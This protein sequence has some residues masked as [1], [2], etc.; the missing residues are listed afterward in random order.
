MFKL[1]RVTLIIVQ[2]VKLQGHIWKYNEKY[3]C[4]YTEH[5]LDMDWA[6]M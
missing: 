1:Q 5:H 2:Q 4:V 3:I 6:L